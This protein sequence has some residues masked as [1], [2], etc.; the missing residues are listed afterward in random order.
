MKQLLLTFVLLVGSFTNAQTFNFSCTAQELEAERIG[1]LEALANNAIYTHV[2]TGYTPDTDEY[3][4]VVI[5]TSLDGTESEYFNDFITYTYLTNLNGDVTGGWNGF[6]ADAQEAV[7]DS[8]KDGK[9]E[10]RSLTNSRTLEIESLSTEDISVVAEWDSAKGHFITIGDVEILSS[11]F[12]HKNYGKISENDFKRLLSRVTEVIA[13]QAADFLKNSIVQYIK[14]VLA[15]GD[16]TIEHETLSNGYDRFTVSFNGAGENG[17]DPWQ[18]RLTTTDPIEELQREPVDYLQFFF[19]QITEI[20]DE[21]QVEYNSRLDQSVIENQ[22]ASANASN[23]LYS[24]TQ[25]EY[26]AIGTEQGGIDRTDVITALDPIYPS[27]STD[28]IN[29]ETGFVG[30]THRITIAIT[31]DPL[32]PVSIFLEAVD[33]GNLSMKD[34]TVDQFNEYYAAAWIFVDNNY[35]YN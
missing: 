12:G 2:E 22:I 14:S 3:A 9:A 13:V 20:V 24:Q 21:A 34:M 1:L 27:N 25:D 29:L 16:T 26:N 32:N 28:G 7:A 8:E 10:L 33:F 4:V 17:S 6:Y 30:G 11:E 19:T 23:T 15:T 31:Q 18:L 5:G 35:I